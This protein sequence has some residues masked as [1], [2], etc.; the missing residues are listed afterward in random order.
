MRG[1]ERPIIKGV[2]FSLAAGESMGMVGPSAAGKSTLARLIVGV[3][4]PTGGAVRLDG[5]DVATWPRERLGPHI[6]YLPQDVE[7]FAGTVADN[8]ARLGEADAAEVIQAAQRA[9]VHDL[10]LRLPKG[11]DTDIGEAGQALSPGQ[12]Q[13][14]GLARALYGRP[15]LVVLDEPNANLDT[16]GDEALLRTLRGLK[17]EGATVIIIAHRPSL[18]GGVDK[19]LVLRDGAVDMFG[20]RAEVM[21][22]ITRAAP[23]APPAARGVA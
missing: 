19:L 1:A 4:K 14:V 21:A 17:E 16:D 9:H 12:R 15:R 23:P 11:Y 18:L 10:I 6:G 3:W 22:K 5:A 13:R 8:I 2:S 20:P 7:L